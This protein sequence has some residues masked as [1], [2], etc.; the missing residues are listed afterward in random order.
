MRVPR[1]CCVTTAA[2]RR[3][4][5]AQPWFAESL[6]RLAGVDPADRE[7]IATHTAAL[8]RAV[9]AA[10]VPDDMAA[11]I[12]DAVSRLGDHAAYAVR[13]SGR[14]SAGRRAG[15]AAHVRAAGGG[16]VLGRLRC[17]TSNEVGSEP[18]V[19]AETPVRGAY[20]LPGA[21]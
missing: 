3:V 4:V 2:F 13:S 5:A 14:R 17:A 7:V 11:A 19:P 1:G 8:R 16:S 18:V 12:A 9:Q 10:V 21:G 15:R 20:H 6:A